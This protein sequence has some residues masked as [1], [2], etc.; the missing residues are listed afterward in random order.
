MEVGQFKIGAIIQARLG[1]TRLPNKVL[2]PLPIGSNETILSQI[3][4]KIKEVDIISDVIVATSKLPIND[5]LEEYVKSL[6]IDCFRGEE[7]DV[8]SRF[9][10][11]SQERNFDYVIRFT[12]DNPVIDTEYLKQF[13]NN[14]LKKK[15][16]YSCSTNLPLGCNFE[17]IKI[18]Q[19]NLAYETTK[20]AYDIEH[21]T[22]FIKN[23]AKNIELYS[24]K[25]FR[26]IKQL[27]LTVDYPSDYAFVQMVFLSLQN[28]D[29]SLNKINK[30]INDCPWLLEINKNN[31]QKKK[32]QNIEQ[33]IKEL[34]PL[35]KEREL[36]R[37]HKL[38]SN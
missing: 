32:Y 26:L 27:R 34:L 29:I 10:H 15:L 11:I 24:F 22:P 16:E 19:L 1:S 9:Y 23:T 2:M 8:L 38:L 36:I 5:R 30:L 35:L 18:D 4:K 17:M 12:G 6:N 37:V 31:F 28:K 7:E 21:V 13:I 25:G 3:I 20:K 14:L 33:E